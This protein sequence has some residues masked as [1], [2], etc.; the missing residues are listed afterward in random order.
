MFRRKFF[1]LILNI[2]MLVWASLAQA[3][4]GLC[5]AHCGGNMPL[6][7]PGGGIPML[8][9]SKIFNHAIASAPVING[10]PITVKM[11]EMA[12]SLKRQTGQ[13]VSRASDY[14]KAPE[15]IIEEFLAHPKGL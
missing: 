6:N 9:F 11:A 2:V 10:I 12:I 13:G 1:I 4:V 14:A 15:H 3:Y 8:L 7:I 5:C